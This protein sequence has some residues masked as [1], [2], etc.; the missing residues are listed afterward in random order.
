STDVAQ[1]LLAQ[2]GLTDAA[3]VESLYL[4]VLNRRA[5]KDEIEQALKYVT[6]FKQKT[7]GEKVE[8]KSWQS[9]CRV[10]MASNDFLYVD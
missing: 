1:S 3:R 6:A 2:T 4:R 8:A 5:E 10:V 7:S 9:L